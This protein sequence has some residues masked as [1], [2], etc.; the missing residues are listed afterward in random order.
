MEEKLATP[1]D[2]GE[3]G[4]PQLTTITNFSHTIII[5]VTIVPSMQSHSHW[6]IDTHNYTT[7]DED[8]LVDPEDGQIRG[9]S[10][11]MYLR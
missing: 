2:S 9:S 5:A 4:T 11:C 8:T 1:L 6:G 3:G 7:L 10:L